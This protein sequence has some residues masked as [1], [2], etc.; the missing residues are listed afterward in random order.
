MRLIRHHRSWRIVLA[1]LCGLLGALMLAGPSSAHV[2]VHPDSMPAGSGDIELTFRVPNERDNANTVGLQVFFPTNF[3]LLTVNVLPV[4]GW[5]ATVAT[6]T[7]STPIQSS[8][9]P[10]NQVVTQV[11]W[12]ATGG[13][14]AP[15]QYQDFD[16]SAGQ[17]PSEA[18]QAVF[19]ALQTYSSGEVVRWIEVPSAQDPNPPTPAPILTLTKT[20]ATAPESTTSTNSGSFEAIAIAALVISI[21]GMVGVA[22]LWLEG[23]RQRPS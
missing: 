23:R 20:A 19:K 21:I 14:I 2:T 12:T 9:G 15:G 22:L 1:G 3:P 4:T 11:T 6:Q 18:G 5:I 8:D 13:G 17:A 7:L 16:V 10:V